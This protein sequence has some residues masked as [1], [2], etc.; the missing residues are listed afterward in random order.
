MAAWVTLSSSAASVKLIWR[1]AASKARNPLSGGRLRFMTLPSHELILSKQDKRSF[2]KDRPGAQ[3]RLREG[4]SHGR[5]F[6]PLQFQGAAGRHLHR[7]Q[8]DPGELAPARP[9]TPRARHPRPA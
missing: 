2:V 4:E 3:I 6:T 8:P 9:R 7:L 5:H 1:A